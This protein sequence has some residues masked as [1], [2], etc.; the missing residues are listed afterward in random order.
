[1]SDKY[2]D[3]IEEILR[4]VGEPVP[5]N[6]DQPYRPKLNKP[7]G[8]V[9]NYLHKRICPASLRPLA[10]FAGIIFFLALMFGG[11]ISG[12]V[13][14]LVMVAAILLIAFYARVRLRPSKI[15]KRWRGQPID[16]DNN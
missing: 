11:V 3:E 8:N 9:W 12:V 16:Y 14:W 13:G 2:K 6:Q 15:K 10:I 4:Q 5:S 7:F 1:M